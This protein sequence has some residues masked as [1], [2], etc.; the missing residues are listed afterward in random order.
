MAAGDKENE[1]KV[2]PLFGKD[3]MNLVEFPFGPITPTKVKTLE[4]EHV[5]FD[6]ILKREVIRQLIMTGSDKWGLPRPIDD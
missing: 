3:E 5:A 1:V 4:V 6:R 2:V